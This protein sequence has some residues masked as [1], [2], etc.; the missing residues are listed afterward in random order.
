M[1]VTRLSSWTLLLAAGFALVAPPAGARQAAKDELPR[2]PPIMNEVNQFKSA[3]LIAPGELNRAKE[4]FAIFAK[5]QAELVSSP[6]VYKTATEFAPDPRN[7]IK[8]L[9]Q[10]NTDLA[11]FLLIPEPGGRFT[12]DQKDYVQEMGAA[13][14]AALKKLIEDGP[15]DKAHEPIVKLNA[16][17]LLATACRTGAAAHYPTV[18]GL[19]RNPGTPPEVKVYALKAAENLLSAYDVYVNTARNRNHSAKA[20]DLVELVQAIEDVVVAPNKL[21]TGQPA[22]GQASPPPTPDELAVVGYVRRQAVKALAQVRFASLTVPP[23]GPTVYPSHTLAR[24]IFADAA[25]NPPPTPAEIA[26]ATLGILNMSPTRDYNLDAAADV[27]ATGI[28]GFATPRAAR[29]EATNKD[30]PW[31][32]Y[33]ARLTEGLRTWKAVADPAYDPGQPTRPYAPPSNASVNQLLDEKTGAGAYIL[34]PMDR[35]VTDPTARL[36]VPK[37]TDLRD[38]IRKSPNRGT[39]LFREVPATSLEFTPRKPGP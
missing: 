33:A 39:T 38:R 11:R 6:V 19:L 34:G 27:V 22:A 12:A 16:A 9:D 23:S 15:A 30:Y 25:L 8:T 37:M 24:V 5:Y 3:P 4:V 7:P 29:P 18:T 14:D 10:I 26:E 36:D 21:V 13:L 35:L 20:K 1:T 17:R 2:Q 32:T 31:R 28:I